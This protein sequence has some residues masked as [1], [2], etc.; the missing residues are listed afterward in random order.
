MKTLIFNGSPRPDGNTSFLIDELKSVLEGETVVV[1]A[2][3]AKVAPC[4]DCRECWDSYGCIIHD[5]MD[6]IY[7]QI[8]A[9]DAIVIASPVYNCELTPPLMTIF[10]RLQSFY[11]ALRFLGVRL[12][13]KGRFGAVVLTGGGDGSSAKAESSAKMFLRH[14]GA[15]PQA[16]VTSLKTDSLLACEDDGA[17]EDIRALGRRINEI[18]KTKE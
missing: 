6:D 1:N 16:L 7:G 8:F 2:Y 10:S 15:P 9:A 17:I 14:M 5:G 13:P 11:A 3:T 4:I 18:G 12:M